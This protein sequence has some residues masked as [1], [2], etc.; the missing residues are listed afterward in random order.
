MIHPIDDLLNYVT[1]EKWGYSHSRLKRTNA[2]IRSIGTFSLKKADLPF[3]KLK[4][5]QWV[6]D[7]K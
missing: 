5:Q 3:F 4:F 7:I 1:Q 2:P 6:P